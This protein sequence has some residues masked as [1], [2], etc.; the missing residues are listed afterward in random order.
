MTLEESDD[1][2][3]LEQHLLEDASWHY[4]TPLWPHR[5]HASGRWL[6]FGKHWLL[7]V[8]YASLTEVFYE[9]RWLHREVG[10]QIKLTIGSL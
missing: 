10:T 5:C 4:R 8:R 9:S 1:Y 3:S 7:R 2:Q 6:W